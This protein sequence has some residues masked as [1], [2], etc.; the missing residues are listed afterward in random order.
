MIV[1]TGGAGF[2]GSRIIKSLNKQGINQIIVVDHLERGEKI[3]NLSEL[4]IYDYF[5]SFE[6]IELFNKKN[7]LK[8]IHTIFHEG[9]C[10]ITTEWNGKYIMEKNFKFSKDLFDNCQSKKIKLIY[11]SS[12]SVYGSKNKDFA[13]KFTNEKPLNPY[14]FSKFLFDQY[15]RMNFKKIKSQVVGLRYFNVYGP[16]EA[17]KKSMTSP[18]FKFYNQLLKKNKISIFKGSH[19]YLDGERQRDFIYVDDCVDV[20]LWFNKKNISGIFN[21]GTGKA[22]SFNSIAK[23]VIKYF[24]KGKVEYIDFPTNLINSYQPFT[25]ANVNKLRKAGYKKKFI[26]IESGIKKYLDFLSI[27]KNT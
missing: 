11:A 5:E 8:K 6:F 23:E 19:D 12:A 20:N 25:K 16:G 17:H 7:S 3:N 9:A 18:V 1:V 24:N 10:S 26:T 15:F 4:D 27:D 2:I 22:S 14:A 13:E 21:V